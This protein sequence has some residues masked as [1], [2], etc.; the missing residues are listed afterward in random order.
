M[1]EDEVKEW[2]E[3]IHE[4]KIKTYGEFLMEAI[5]SLNDNKVD[6]FIKNNWDGKAKTFEYNQ[7]AIIEFGKVFKDVI[8][9][10]EKDYF[11]ISSTQTDKQTA[12]STG[13]IT[14]Y[15][16]KEVE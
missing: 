14:K 7:E 10:K 4:S 1:D 8:V 6:D 12:V 16:L 13:I 11:H 15:N 5:R 9:S 2:G 3:E